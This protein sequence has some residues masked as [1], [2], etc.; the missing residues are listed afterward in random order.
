MGENSTSIAKDKAVRLVEYLLRLASL[1][2]QLVRD[3]SV[4]KEVLWI[5]DIPRQKG[6]FTLAWG[7]DEDYEL[8][9]W[10]EIQ[11]RREPELP[12]VPA[13]CKDW[14]VEDSL[15]KKNDL[16]ELLIEIQIQV[17]NPAWA[18]GSDQ[19][20]FIQHKQHLTDHPDIQKAWDRYLEE[21]W[22]PWVEEHNSW[23]SIH[24][25]YSALFAIHQEQLRLGEEYELII[26]IGL[27]TWLTPSGQRIRRHLI[28]ANALL[29]FEAR[30]GKFTI[31]PDID[32]AKAR[33]EFD[34]L[35]IE[36]QPAQVEESTKIS[37]AEFAENPWEKDHI[38]DALKTIVKSINA[39]GEYDDILES[40]NAQPTVRPVVEYAPAIIL[41]ERSGRGLTETLRRIRE[42]I[43]NGE[44]IPSEFA[45]LAEIG[46]NG[47]NEMEFDPGN[48]E[49]DFEGEIIFPKPSNEEQR[50]IVDKIQSSNG[51][52]VQGPPGTGKSH[53]IANLICH[54]L[55]T[56][57]RMLITAKTPRALQVLEG[58]MPEELRPLC[59]NLLGSGLEEKRSL[60]SSISGILRERENWNEKKAADNLRML[61]QSLNQ[62]REEKAE[63]DRRLR[64]IRESETHSLTI[65][66]TKYRGTAAQIAQTVNKERSSF[67]W[68]DDAVSLDQ[69]CPLAENELLIILRFLRY[70]T[71][72]KQQELDLALPSELPSSDEF[73]GFVTQEKEAINE[74]SQASSEADDKTALLLSKTERENI[75]GILDSLSAFINQRKRI[76]ASTHSWTQS[77]LS[78]VIG[79]NITLW[80]EHFRFTMAIINAIETI[81]HIADNNSLDN[82]GK[83]EIKT[84][85]D[86]ALTLEKHMENGGKLGWGPFRPKQV[87]D[88]IYILKT[89]SLNG[90]RINSFDDIRTLTRILIVLNEIE[91]A[92]SFWSSRCDKIQGPYVLQLEALRALCDELNGV[93]SIEKTIEQCR[94]ALRKCPL[95]TEPDWADESMVK[96]MVA[97]CRLAQAYQNQRRIETEFQKI[98][99]PI[100]TLIAKDNIHPIVNRI[101]A[102][103]RDR[104][105][106]A[107]NRCLAKIQELQ[108]EKSSVQKMDMN[109]RN[110]SK[111]APKLIQ[112]LTQTFSESNWEMRIQQIRNAWDW[113]RANKYIKDYL[114]KDDAPSLVKRSRQI[115]N[116]ISESIGLIAA[117]RAWSFCFSRLKENHTREMVAWQQSM[118]RLGKGTGK[119][120]SRHRREA[121]QHLNKCREAVPAWVMPLHRVWDT[122]DPAPGLFDI[123]IVDEASQCGFEAN[124]LFYLGKKILIV[125][126]DKQISPEEGF[127]DKNLVFRLMEQFLYDFEF[128]DSFHR[129]ASIFDHAKLR[130]GTNHIVLREHF[131]CMP[132]I[133]RFSNDLCYFDTPLIPLRQYG[134]NRLLPLK[135]VFVEGGYREGSSSRTINRP[136]AKAIVEKISELCRDRKYNIKTMGVIALQ[137]ETQANLIEK[138]LLDRIGAVEME[139]RRLICGNPYSFQG[140]ERDVIFLSM[141][142]GQ[143][144]ASGLIKEGPTDEKRYNVA[145]SRARDQMWLFHSVKQ[146]DLSQAR[147][148]KRLL[149]FFEG[150]RQQEIGGLNREELERRAAQDNREIVK[151]PLPFDSWFEVDV[152]LELLR[153]GFYVIPQFQIAGKRIDLVIE[154]GYQRLA[155]ECDGD[156]W[157]GSEQY[158]ED[159]QRQRILERCGLEFYRIRE[160]AFRFNKESSLLPLWRLL[161]ERDIFPGPLISP[162][163]TEDEYNGPDV[164]SNK[165]TED[166]NG[167]DEEESQNELFLFETN[168]AARN[169]R[170]RRID[171]IS[172]SEIQNAILE[173]LRKCPNHSCTLQSL[174]S[175]VLRELGVLTR[176][177]PRLEFEK[178]VLRNLG[179]LERK[180]IIEKYRAKNRRIRLLPT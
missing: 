19:P 52:L 126:D 114:R 139:K 109:I 157:H 23:E 127:V 146:E 132:E 150:T 20:E 18:H 134:P 171:E 115:E 38:V 173:S 100:T 120:A 124:P 26:G 11:N 68:F 36:E 148:R 110:L 45:D 91:K 136:E 154:G 69:A 111:I 49:T 62:L 166:D 118:R 137:G 59:I 83:I 92:W 44:K 140:D 78:D 42:R 96:R 144:A 117:L 48:S 107:Y 65:A 75:Q 73:V 105:T 170:H 128:K 84:L 142:A 175:R 56:G 51:V 40:K 161:E 141:V 53:T 31:R 163:F 39:E 164:E 8:D 46:Q 108:K 138:M 102:V 10:V 113:A 129:D 79:G 151:P 57:Q 180:E 25:V 153:R 41:R 112:D 104:N 149:E 125:G 131:R 4:Y 165:I 81:V 99:K 34:M 86:D 29:D 67:E 98:E 82:P 88:R 177:N 76:L 16:P 94:I 87:R 147:L 156:K 60:E 71:P 93:L 55:A 162:E 130:Y 143:D 116:G 3:I 50:R 178:R 72:E 22:L 37:L 58:L 12:S 101:L 176:G 1:R 30:L 169:Q 172:A 167:E 158:E 155:V 135:S 54:L 47:E 80:R 14:I 17:R 5:S 70:I 95:F 15:R 61:E 24:K 106:E 168:M 2:A 32:G 21:R 64:A 63:I 103:I 28:V 13:I 123:I 7:L 122:V 66:Q 6:C 85:L 43:G 174:T 97:S 119:H 74:L 145:A 159:M 89:I 35:D 27:L 179:N 77:A 152:A 121:Q 9:I 33:P 90:H 133:I 160:S